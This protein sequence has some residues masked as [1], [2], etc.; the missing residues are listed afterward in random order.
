MWTGNTEGLDYEFYGDFISENNGTKN[1][2]EV[3]LQV[4]ITILIT[5][6]KTGPS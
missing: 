5:L 4:R 1:I 6:I 3:K 2:G